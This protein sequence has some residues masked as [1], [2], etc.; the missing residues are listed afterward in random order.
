MRIRGGSRSTTTALASATAG[1][2]L[3]KGDQEHWSGESRVVFGFERGRKSCAIGN[4]L[5]S[6]IN[7]RDRGKERE[8][9]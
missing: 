6:R 7:E 2:G 9:V 8:K 5:R 4:F 1:S 3:V